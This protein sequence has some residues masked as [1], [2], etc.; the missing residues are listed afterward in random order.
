MPFGL[1]R[2]VRA[3]AIAN[4]MWSKILDTAIVAY[5]L[6]LVIPPHDVGNCSG[7][8]SFK[9][10]EG[11]ASSCKYWHRSRYLGFLRQFFPN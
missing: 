2:T 7:P 9:C 5:S 11:L 3:S 10:R 1:Q 6:A 8:G 4:D